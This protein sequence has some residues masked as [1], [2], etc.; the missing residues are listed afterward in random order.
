MFRSLD[1]SE[2]C[3]LNVSGDG[4]DGG[5]LLSSARTFARPLIHVFAFYLYSLF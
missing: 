5:R 2:S 4:G 3:Y 1:W